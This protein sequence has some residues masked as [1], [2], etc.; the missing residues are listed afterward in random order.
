MSSNKVFIVI[1]GLIGAGKTTLINLLTEKYSQQG[2]KVCPIL[3]PVELWRQTGA[4]AHF[5][6][7]VNTRA[8]E[9]QTFAYVSR[10]RAVLDALE[11]MPDADIYLMERSIYTDRYI[12]VETLRNVFGPVRLAMYNTWWDMWSR[13]LPMKITTWVYLDTGLEEAVRR[14]CIR[15]RTEEAGVS[16]DYQRN[17]QLAHT[18]FYDKLT[19]DG[20]HVIVIK[21]ELMNSNFIEHPDILDQIAEQILPYDKKTVSR[22]IMVSQ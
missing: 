2:F 15:D 17:L 9:F 21:P 18:R 11:S 12:F 13:L 8:Y 16:L 22:P 7:D 1:D 14:I 10:V 5:Y 20:C 19:E 6:E 3:E 4:L